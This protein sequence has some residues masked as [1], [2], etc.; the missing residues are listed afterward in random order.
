MLTPYALLYSSFLTFMILIMA[1]N[2]VRVR[3]KLKIPLGDG[4][5]NEMLV[6]MRIHGNSLEYV[7]VGMILLFLI[8]YN[9]AQPWMMNLVGGSLLVGRIF[10][11]NGLNQGTGITPGRFIG[12]TLTWF[13]LFFAAGAC[14]YL[15]LFY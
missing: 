10:H 8:E 14:I 2:S 13:S 15:A 3:R 5:N 4:G 6:A 7:P 9:G 1:I 12:T 11:A